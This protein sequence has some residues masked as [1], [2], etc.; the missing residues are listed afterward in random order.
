MEIEAAGPALYTL[1]ENVLT[2][3]VTSSVVYPIVSP[4]AKYKPYSSGELAPILQVA[5][6]KPEGSPKS[7]Y[8][9]PLCVSTFF[10]KYLTLL[11]SSTKDTFGAFNTPPI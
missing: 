8:S 3:D 6:F 11:S 10:N 2:L 1:F 9:Y 4:H 7:T 5:H